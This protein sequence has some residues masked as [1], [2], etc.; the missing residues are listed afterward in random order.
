MSAAR[1]GPGGRV[2][3]RRPQPHA[4]WGRPGG[5]GGEGPPTPPPPVMPLPSVPRAPIRPAAPKSI[6]GGRKPQRVADWVRSRQ[7]P[8]P[9]IGKGD[10][11]VPS[12]SSSPPPRAV[13]VSAGWPGR[14]GVAAGLAAA[15][16]EVG[17]AAVAGRAGGAGGAGREGIG[18]AAAGGTAAGTPHGHR[19]PRE[20][21]RGGWMS[22]REAPG[23]GRGGAGSMR[24]GGNG[25][26]ML[27]AAVSSAGQFLPAA[28]AEA[29]GG[30]GW[31]AAERAVAPVG[32]GGG[33]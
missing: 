20:G 30:A 23:P 25:G 18:V 19:V 11:A 22:E 28:A 33:A 13:R 1:A 10:C 9:T 3:W 15:P 12:S 24:H 29:P 14:P 4:R 32:A 26:G 27:R 17:V 7:P 5:G 16:D 6:G 2:G 31:L 8:H 21:W